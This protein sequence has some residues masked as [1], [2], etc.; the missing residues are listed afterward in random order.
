MIVFIRLSIFMLLLV[1]VGQFTTRFYIREID[2]S[3]ESQIEQLK[4]ETD[5]QENA[6][7][8]K[9]IQDINAIVADYN[10]L[11]SSTPKWSAVVTAFA[12]HVPEGVKLQTF[13]ADAAK[14][15]IDIAGISPTREKVIELYNSIAGDT[16][17]FANIDY[18]LENIARP[19]N[20]PFHFTF[21]IKE[22][23]LRK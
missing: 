10:Q 21:F 22:D 23:F 5:K 19:V 4:L 12:G 13:S 15:K 16:E 3:Y 20:V 9:Q 11:A 14:L 1:F 7:L 6:D 2:H 8:K 17:H 18:P